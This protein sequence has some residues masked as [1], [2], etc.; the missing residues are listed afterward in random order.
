MIFALL[1]KTVSAG[2]I[3]VMRNMQTKRLHNCRPFFKIHDMGLV[4]ILCKQFPTVLKLLYFC[5][6]FPDVC[7][8]IAVFQLCTNFFIL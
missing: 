4:H 5:R 7:F 2:E 8:R 1:C 3:A 6:R